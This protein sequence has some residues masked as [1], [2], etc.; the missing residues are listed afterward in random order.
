MLTQASF[1][2]KNNEMQA[3]RFTLP[4][5][6]ELWSTFVNGQPAK[7]ERD[8]D[9]ILVSLPRDAN[10]DQA[11]AVDIVYKQSVELKSSLFPRRLELKAPL[12]DVPNTYAEWALFVP[13]NQRLSGFDGNMTVASGTTYGLRDAW[14][15]CLQFYWRLVER[16]VGVIIL[17]LVLSVLTAL[18]I[19]AARRGMKRAIEIIVVLTIIALL[20]AMLLPA[21]SKA[22]S[23]AQRISAMSNL[24]QVGLA[25]RI[26]S[27]DNSDRMP[28]SF[29][30][31]KAELGTDKI[32]VDPN[33]GQRFVWVGAGKDA[34]DPSAILAYSPSDQNGRAVLLADGSV[35]QVNSEKFS[36]ML[37]RDEENLRARQAQQSVREFAPKRLAAPG[38]TA[39]STV[40][41]GPP[42]PAPQTTPAA[43]RRR[44]KL[45]SE[46]DTA[47]RRVSCG[48]PRRT[49]LGP[50]SIVLVCLRLLSPRRDHPS[51]AWPQRPDQARRP[52][53]PLPGCGPFGLMCRAADTSS[54]SPKCSTSNANHSAS[55]RRS[56]R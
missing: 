8:G 53:P 48:I 25:A 50:I 24:K 42:P 13:M 46:R 3:Q 28:A 5:G 12:T 52:N 18:I 49:R 23:K 17:C 51:P 4:K 6:A 56:C 10:R 36:E 32:T 38:M 21:L 29:E 16:N 43:R 27:G 15:E 34:S 1:M 30:D 54:I 40:M 9:D 22:K 7:P 55:K 26:W 44:T 11:F 47:W 31:M 45:R 35:Q 20:G 41:D 39:G 33:T 19:A 14:E 37:V 2:V